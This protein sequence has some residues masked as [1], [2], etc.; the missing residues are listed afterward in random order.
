MLQLKVEHSNHD[1]FKFTTFSFM[2][3]PTSSL[4][5]SLSSYENLLTSDF[6]CLKPSYKK[7][8]ILNTELLPYYNTLYYVR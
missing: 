7:L 8:H 2:C 6:S 4:L 5:P 1:I 3:Q